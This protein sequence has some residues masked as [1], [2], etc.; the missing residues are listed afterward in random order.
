MKKKSKIREG[1]TTVDHIGRFL[2]V[3]EV[4]PADGVLWVR[5]AYVRK[6][7]RVKYN[8]KTHIVYDSENVYLTEPEWQINL[9]KSL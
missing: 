9:K 7:F 4:F 2:M 1:Q 8:K 3:Q 5:C 6:T